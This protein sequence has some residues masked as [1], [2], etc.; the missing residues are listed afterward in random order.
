MEGLQQLSTD[1]LLHLWGP[2]SV[3]NSLLLAPGRRIDSFTFGRC[4][5]SATH[6]HTNGN[7]RLTVSTTKLPCQTRCS[8]TYF[9]GVC[10]R[11]CVCAGCHFAYFLLCNIYKQAL[12][13]SLK[14]E[15]GNVFDK[16]GKESK[17]KRSDQRD[18]FH[19]ERRRFFSNSIKR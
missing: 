1:V 16:L 18:V 7:N 15:R 4:R 6:I 2:C 13:S 3:G 14:C 12:M 10:S 17:G 9:P 8:I 5:S 11:L 19:N